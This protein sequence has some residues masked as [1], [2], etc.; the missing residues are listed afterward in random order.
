MAE[1]RLIRD[2]LATLT[3]QLPV[4]ITDE[5]ADGLAETYRSYLRQGLPPDPAAESAVAEFG[6]PDLILAEFARVNPARRA[7]RRLI[8]TGP[9]VGACW[10]AAL[11]SG[12]AW[13]WHVPLPA[14]IT[15][16]LVLVT[17]IALIVVAAAAGTRYRVATRAGLAG[18]IGITALDITMITGVTLAAPALTLV[19]V[20]A[21][22][23]SVTRIAF[24]TRAVVPLLTR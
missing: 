14:R 24:S 6:D 16:G 9:V 2:Y 19:T 4:P 10:A 20:G 22:A 12:R 18:C 21:L 13:T 17:A 15:P 1:P 3:A 23:A 11:I 8:M 7:A 5:L